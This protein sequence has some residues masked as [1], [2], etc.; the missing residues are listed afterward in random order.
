MKLKG[1]RQSTNVIDTTES[2]SLK[3]RLEEG[4]KK[5][6]R[7]SLFQYDQD[8]KGMA[9]KRLRQPESI[10]NNEITQED[11]KRAKKTVRSSLTR[12]KNLDTSDDPAPKGFLPV[13]TKNNMKTNRYN[14]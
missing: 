8:E 14:Y 4:N 12:L 11:N 6:Y 5:A 10:K 13:K 1:Q 2:E 3:K 7:K 9:S